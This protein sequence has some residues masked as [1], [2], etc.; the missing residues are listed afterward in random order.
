MYL[1]PTRY[2]YTTYLFAYLLEQICLSKVTKYIKYITILVLG[3]EFGSRPRPRKR[4][5][6]GYHGSV[7]KRHVYV[8]E[9]RVLNRVSSWVELT[10]CKW[11]IETT[12]LGTVSGFRNGVQGQCGGVVSLSLSLTTTR[13]RTK[14][15]DHYFSFNKEEV[16]IQRRLQNHF[17][18][19]RVEQITILYDFSLQ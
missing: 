4:E 6:Q 19:E 17:K 3:T 2:L 9:V 11:I 8:T 16:S 15:I 14:V 5:P 7:H 10:L 18:E 1:V 13:L 12:F